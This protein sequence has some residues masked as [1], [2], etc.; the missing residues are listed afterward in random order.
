MPDKLAH[1]TTEQRASYHAMHVRMM[2]ALTYERVTVAGQDALNEWERLRSAGRGWPVVIGDEEDLER[3]AEQFSI[4]DLFMG[5]STRPRSWEEILAAA[6]TIRFPQDLRKWPGA[7]RAE[8]LH[9]ALGEWP[10]PDGNDDLGL[11]VATDPVSGK[12]KDKVHI[13]LLPTARSWEV[14]AYL[15]WGNWNACPPPEYHVAALREWHD[16]FGADLVGINGDTMN[17]RVRTRP[18]DRGRS[19]ALARDL[20]GY[21]PDIVDQGVETIAALA[22]TLMG[23]DWWY[24]WW[25]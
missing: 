20:Y 9:A 4:D 22:A 11:T 1:L 18:K 5:G 12:V 21:C 24:L 8:D 14:P 7:Y 25:D 15:R 16:R 19:L 2:A 23:S 6:K 17:V 10:D 13:L 3:I